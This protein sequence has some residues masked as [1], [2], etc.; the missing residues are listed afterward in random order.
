MSGS[1]LTRSRSLPRSRTHSWAR[2]RSG[3]GGTDLNRFSSIAEHPRS[4]VRQGPICIGLVFLLVIPMRKFTSIRLC[5]TLSFSFGSQK[6]LLT[7]YLL[8]IFLMS[9]HIYSS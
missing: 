7:T 5:L 1:T 6:R 9:I 2:S 8:Y 3:S 4:V